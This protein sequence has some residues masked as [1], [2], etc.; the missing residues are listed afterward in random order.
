LSTFLPIPRR[1]E[2]LAECGGG[3]LDLSECV[4]SVGIA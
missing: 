3:L 4:M 2:S 1:L